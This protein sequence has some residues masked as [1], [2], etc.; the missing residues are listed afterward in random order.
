[1]P[2][3]SKAQLD[4]LLDLQWALYQRQ[5]AYGITED[6]KQTMNAAQKVMRALATD[7]PTPP[8]PDPTDPFADLKWRQANIGSWAAF[9][10]TFFTEVNALIEAYPQLHQTIAQLNG[11]YGPG[12][13][14]NVYGRRDGNAFFYVDIATQ[15]WLADVSNA[16][17]NMIL[18]QPGNPDHIAPPSISIP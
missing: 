13:F 9:S 11:Y 16:A 8:G 5:E 15:T 7:T 1:M 6:C 3:I 10:P 18:N 2:K 14:G 12:G 17:D 4:D